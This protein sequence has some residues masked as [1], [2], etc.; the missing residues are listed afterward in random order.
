MMYDSRVNQCINQM[1]DPMNKILSSVLNSILMWFGLVYYDL[2]LPGSD[3]G[4]MMDSFGFV[5]D[6]HQNNLITIINSNTQYI[7]HPFHLGILSNVIAL[8]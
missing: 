2:R 4:L 3:Q 8:L 1:N 6:D 5:T 7:I